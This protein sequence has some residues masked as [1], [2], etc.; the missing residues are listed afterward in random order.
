MIRTLIEV[1]ADTQWDYEKQLTATLD[2]L[3]YEPKRSL[4]QEH[5]MID[6]HQVL[7]E[8]DLDPHKLVE[9]YRAKLFSER[10]G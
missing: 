2:K 4:E 8:R 10:L 3:G 6:L 9:E 5:Y 7:R 1:T